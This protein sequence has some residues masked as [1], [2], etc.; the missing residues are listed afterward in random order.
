[1]RIK[2][3]LAVS[4]LMLATSG[5][6]AETTL[7]W[8]Q[9]WT[10][11]TIKPTIQ[12]IVE[13]FEKENPDI[14][15]KVTDLT[16]ANGHEKLVM[17]FASGTAPDIVELGSD[18]LTEF[19][20]NDHIEDITTYIV[21]DSSE[22]VGWSMATYNSKVYAHPWILGTRVLFCNRDLIRQAGYDDIYFPM[23]WD[24]LKEMV[25][26][27]SALGDDIY[28]WG[29][30][31]PEKHRLYKK[32]L[33]FFW[34]NNAQIFTDDNRYC[35]I[36]SDYA[37][38]ALEYYFDLHNSKAYVA[39]QRGIEDAFLDG[40]VGFVISGDWLLKR[41]KQEK[42]KLNFFTTLIPGPQFPGKS[43]MGGEFLAVNKNSENKEAALKFIDF[44][45]SEENQLR[46]C[47]ANTAA[48]PSN[49]Y[50]QT[51]EYFQLND[52]LLVFIK[53]LYNSKHPPLDP[54]W[55]YIEEIIEKA[56]EDVLMYIETPSEALRQ[57]QHQIAALKKN[58]KQ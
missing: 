24:Q 39:D 58:E 30:N 38:E 51:N 13:D 17:A 6:Y 23:K 46:F 10:D 8:W 9:F 19:I 16:W 37:I 15:V 5:A 21:P 18:W 55:V 50:T 44:V 41:I 27:I 49:K 52:N 29:S 56:V 36:S 22:F 1:M 43:F 34:S 7:E 31:T 45:T 26:K 57:A 2:T 14:K 35:V 33:P 25:K 3:L 28:G 11:P 4:L 12:A 53:Q 42:R 47:K 20:V 54:E 48:N 32:F 40:K